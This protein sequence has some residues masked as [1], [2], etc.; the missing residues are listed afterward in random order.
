MTDNFR[1]I[2]RIRQFRALAGIHYRQ[3]EPRQS[4]PGRTRHNRRCPTEGK[5]S[6]PGRTA[7]DAA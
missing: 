4:F 2:T 3:R 7:P 5:T 6:R 1:R